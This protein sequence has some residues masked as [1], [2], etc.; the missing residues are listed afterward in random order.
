LLKFMVD[1]STGKKVAQALK[2]KYSDTISVI[3]EM[4]GAKDREIIER[5]I[6]EQRIL[7][8]NDKDFGEL[9]FRHAFS[10]RGV[11]LLRLKEESWKN[12]VRVLTKVLEKCEKQLEAHF[13]VATE[14]TVRKRTMR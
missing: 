14:G 9:V 4:P 5:A 8:T 12:K 3:D 1:E 7:I 11:V 2:H 10:V 13:I 6:E